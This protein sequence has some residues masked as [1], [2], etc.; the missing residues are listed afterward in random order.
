MLRLRWFSSDDP[1]GGE[2][3]SKSL[4]SVHGAP[5]YAKPSLAA[6]AFSADPLARI[7]LD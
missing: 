7:L 1:F 4:W 3:F 2:L 5:V 6:G